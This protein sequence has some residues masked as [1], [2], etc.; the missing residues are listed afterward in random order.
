MSGRENVSRCVGVRERRCRLVAPERNNRGRS[1]LRPIRLE[2]Q[3]RGDRQGRQRIAR[4]T[5]PAAGIPISRRRS[6]PLAVAAALKL[7]IGSLYHPYSHKHVLKQLERGEMD[8]LSVA[9]RR[10]RTAS[11]RWRREPLHSIW[12]IGPA[13][14]LRT[15]HCVGSKICR[16]SRRSATSLAPNA[17]I[18]SLSARYTHLGERGRECR[19]ADLIPANGPPYGIAPSPRRHRAV[20]P[21][22]SRRPPDGI[23]LW[24]ACRASIPA[25]PTRPRYSLI[26]RRSCMIGLVVVYCRCTLCPGSRRALIAKAA[27]AAS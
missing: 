21:T 8:A 14:L 4:P 27:S 7:A 2:F 11:E 9:L 18:P 15:V 22:A 25:A 12:Q 19:A 5:V 26:P 6:N 13:R 16:A 1:K 10:D 20:P 23:A 24:S 3:E 17:V